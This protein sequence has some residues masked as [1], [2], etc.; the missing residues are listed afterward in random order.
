VK[1]KSI[2]AASLAVLGFAGLAFAQVS[3][4]MADPTEVY[5]A[6]GSDTIQDISNQLSV[7]LGSNTLG[8]YNA[9]NPVTQAAH[10][11]ITPVKATTGQ[12]CSFAR[13][14]GSGEGVAALRFSVNSGSGAAPPA[15]Q[16]QANC[17]DIARSSSGPGTNASTTGV[18]V[19]IPFALDAVAGSTGPTAAGTIGGVNAVATA[20]TQA[21]SFTLTDLKN[22]YANCMPITEG[23]VTYDPTGNVAADT[24]IDLYIPQAGS[25][26][27]N[28]WATTLGFNNTTPPTCVHDTIV[29]GADVGMSVEEHDGT[30]VA[31][32]A[33][34]FGP[35]SVA[36]WIAQRNGHNDRRHGA[37]IYSL[38]G[39]SPFSNGNPATG[40][41]N[42]A[43]PITR[44]VYN[45]VQ[46]SRVSGST[47]DPGLV[48]MLVSTNSFLCQDSLNIKSF[49]F[50]T[51]GSTTPDT[52]GSTASTLRAFANG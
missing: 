11:V 35:F 5:V 50:A 2:A 27:R 21:G 45:V 6:V 36:Q 7:D 26:T 19:Y 18:F 1:R 8:S 52:C 43:F 28:F 40:S 42:T 14:N 25:G 15:P 49:G 31:T 30:A 24:P 48:A 22:L 44:E 20:I 12:P 3:P 17:V 41:L 13:P 38:N 51:L 46:F 23:G 39:T 33:N 16:P 32:D 10:E 4:A 47:A 29:A 9:V 37:Q 34:G